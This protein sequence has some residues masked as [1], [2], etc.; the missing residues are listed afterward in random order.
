M[1]C[2]RSE[3]ALRLIAAYTNR[4]IDDPDFIGITLADYLAPEIITIVAEQD[5]LI[6]FS[7]EARQEKIRRLNAE[8]ARH[9]ELVRAWQVPRFWVVQKR[10]ITLVAF[11]PFTRSRD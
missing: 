9:Q 4:V 8:A 6:E 1:S 7:E 5:L 10:Y 11:V 3:A 2:S